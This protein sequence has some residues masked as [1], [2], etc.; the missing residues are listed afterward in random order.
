MGNRVIEKVAID[1]KDLKEKIKRYGYS[2][3]SLG[4]SIG[5]SDRQIRSYLDAN[6][7][8]P[9]MLRLINGKIDNIE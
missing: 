1:G 9:Y 6:V 8:P 5:V 7:M 4:E 3:R 2:L